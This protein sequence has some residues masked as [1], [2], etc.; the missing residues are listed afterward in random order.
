MITKQLE[1][2]EPVKKNMIVTEKDFN[3]LMSYIFYL[4]G[5]PIGS[6]YITENYWDKIP[7][8]YRKFLKKRVAISPVVLS[9]P[10][11]YSNI[12]NEA[13]N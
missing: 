2:G 11:L 12:I 13:K 1:I 8:D 4:I 5:K 6:T 10:Q 7:G 3:M 9:E